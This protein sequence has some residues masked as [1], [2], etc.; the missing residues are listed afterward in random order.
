MENK[1][2]I[3]QKVQANGKEFAQKG[4]DAVEKAYKTTVDIIAQAKADGPTE[5][6]NKLVKRG[7]S[8]WADAKKV[9][10]KLF[11][12][13]AE[14]LVTLQKDL[15]NTMEEMR[16]KIIKGIPVDFKALQELVKKI[17]EQIGKIDLLTQIRQGSPEFVNNLL[18]KSET[19]WEDAKKKLEGLFNENRDKIMKLQKDV[20]KTLDEYR[21]KILKDI[22][23]DLTK[24][25]ELFKKVEDKIGSLEIPFFHQAES[26][27]E[28][29]IENYDDLNVKTIVPK[30]AGLSEEA[31]KAIQD[32]EAAHQNRVSI[33]REIDKLLKK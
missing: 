27:S 32:Y 8:E 4:S 33:K 9:V 23:V 28:L 7:E 24:V 5:T 21:E 18:K 14:K 17:E 2:N 6:L 1:Q 31:L 19:E 30:L 10:E 20:V 15:F 22:P 12:E 25:Q 13:N 3:I 16:A 26:K 11:K 29:A